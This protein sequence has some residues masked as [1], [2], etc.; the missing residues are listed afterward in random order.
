MDQVRIG[1]TKTETG[2]LVEIADRPQM[3]L[4][5][6]YQ[7]EIEGCAVAII[8]RAALLLANGNGETAKRIISA[9]CEQAKEKLS[10]G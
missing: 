9:M 8:S 7:D 5:T 6:E 3:V 2:Y 1:A 10:Q 4:E